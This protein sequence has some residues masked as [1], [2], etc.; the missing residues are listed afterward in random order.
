MA[1]A[2]NSYKQVLKATSVFGGVQVFTILIQVIRSKCIAILL[3]PAG[4]GI[5]A[6]LYSTINIIGSITNFGLA[7]SAVKNVA[8]SFASGDEKKLATTATVFKKLVWI[9]GLLGFLLT[10]ILSPFLSEFA[11][12]NKTF[13]LAFILVAITLLFNQLAEGQNVLLRG[14]RNIRD[15]AKASSFG[16]LAGLLISV[17]LYYFFSDRGIVPAIVLTSLAALLISLFYS[18]KLKIPRV[19]LPKEIFKAEAIDMLKMGFLLS[20]SAMITMGVS[21]LVTIYISA[22]SGV[23]EVG[24][25]NAGFAIIGAYAGMVFSA[26]SVDYY[27]RLAA[28]AQD[29]VKC[30]SE[31]N[32]QAE[33][34]V[35]ILAPIL[36]LFVVFI[37][38]GII[39]LYSKEFLNVSEMLQWAAL[40]IFF[41]AASWAIGMIFVSKGASRVFFWNEL[42]TNIYLG[43]LNILGYYLYG[44]TG[45]GI[46]FLIVYFIHFIQML[47]VAKKLYKI[48]FKNEFLGIF[49]F[50]LSLAILAFLGAR[51]LPQIYGYALGVILFAISLFY[52]WKQLNKKTGLKEMIISKFK[53]GKTL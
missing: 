38:F 51:F 36:I 20:L 35:L 11:F 33:I 13:T 1:E 18:R 24:L 7:R 39:I 4:M 10:V 32:Q 41:K 31:I 29:N 52:S 22:K 44:L 50:Q 37:K 21:Y 6:L 45:L 28:I 42:L 19:Q 25:Y 16:A 27:P 17:P 12:H 40:G 2:S 43:G 14:T 34:A 46:S 23:H 49:F 8:V 47:L 9:T 53:K 48:N 3:G 26:M 5:A 15:M 30:E